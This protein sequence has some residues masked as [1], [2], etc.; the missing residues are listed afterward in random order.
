MIYGELRQLIALSC[1][2][3]QSQL[4]QDM[5]SKIGA[6]ATSYC[7]IMPDIKWR[8]CVSYSSHHISWPTLSSLPIV[9]ESANQV[10]L[11]LFFISV[12]ESLPRDTTSW[13]SSRG[14]FVHP[15]FSHLACIQHVM[16]LGNCKNFCCLRFNFLSSLPWSPERV[17]SRESS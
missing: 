17:G 6:L 10:F 2:E 3:T 12:K 13:Q 8:D 4:S 11:S 7:R 9:W 1:H 15:C 14:E 16:C 5:E